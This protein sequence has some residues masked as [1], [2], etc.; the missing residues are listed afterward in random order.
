MDQFVCVRLVQANT[1]DLARFQFDFDLTFAAFLMNADLTIY[2]RFGSRSDRKDAMRDMTMEGFRKALAAAVDLHKS[3]PGNKASLAGKIGP[4]VRFKTPIEYPTLQGKYKASLDYEGKVVQ[5]CVHCHQVRDA[6]FGL[7]RNDRKPI[8]DEVLYSWPMPG[9]LGFDLDPNEKAKVLRVAQGSS[10]ERDGF[11]PGDEILT[12]NGQPLLS[13][14]DVQWALH[15]APAQGTV[16]A[17]IQRGT[18]RISRNLSL[19]DGWRKRVDISW[20]ATSWDLRR[21]AMGGLLLHELSEQERKEAQL[22]DGQLGL[23]A[24][25]VGEYGE[26]AAAK[27][28]GFQKGDILIEVDGQTGRM[29]ESALFGYLLQKHMPGTRIPITVQRQGERV[30]L[31]LPMQ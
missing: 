16:Q 19:T 11:R 6:E 8:P 7:L 17:V 31:E 28:A 30:K 15:N 27:R 12:L 29:S 5:S 22:A 18:E 24:Q 26:H 21:M 25:H 10:A 14:A 2:G 1:I 23:V 13:I 20:R 4:E 3:Y 9:V